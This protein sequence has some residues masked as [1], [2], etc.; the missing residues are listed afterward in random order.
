M[1]HLLI[2]GAALAA[3]GAAGLDY[4]NLNADGMFPFVPS[5]EA[6]AKDSVMDMSHL[7]DAPAGR[8]GFV[9]VVDGRFATDAGRLRLHASNL[10]GPANFPTHAKAERLAERMARFGV[11]CV[12]L[13]YFDAD[14][15]TFMLPHQ[16]GIVAK[17]F[18]TGCRLDPQQ[19]DR[20]DYLV[21]QFKKR[22][23][24]VNVNLHVAR[25]LDA[26]DGFAPGTPWANKG[27]SQFDPR[28]IAAEKAYAKE[29]LEHVNPYTGLAYRD[30]PCVA[31]V[32]LNNE[33]AIFSEYFHGGLDRLP[34][35]YATSL[36]ILWN[37][38][39]L[40]KYG[41]TDKVLEAWAARAADT[42]L[43]PETIA[44]TA[45]DAPVAMDM[46]TWIPEPGKAALD[47]AVAD[48][49]LRLKTARKNDEL[50]PKVHRRVVLKSGRPYT[51]SFRARLLEDVKG[52]KATI[53]FA[54]AN[55]ANG[56][57]ASRGV[58]EKFELKRGWQTFTRTF[59]ANADDAAAEIQF[60][61]LPAGT[62][63]IDDLSFR[64]GGTFAKLDQGRIEEGTMPVVKAGDNVMPATRRDFI[65]F[66]A[67]QERAYFTDMRD[68][69]VKE[70]G[71]KVPV[72]GTQLGYSPA[73]VQASIDYVDNHAYWY[74]PSVHKGWLITNKA[75]VNSPG[76]GC[77]Y[78]LATQRV[79]GK[80][81]TVSEY[82][83]PYPNFFGAEGQPML[84]AFGAYQGWDGVFEYSW[85]NR[86]DSEP[87]HT[88]YFF[89]IAA[90]TDVLA[91][92]PACAAM[93]LRGDVR[94]SAS[95]LSVPLPYD[96]YLD[97]LATRRWCA[98]GIDD[99]PQ[100][101]VPGS[102]FFV[103]RVGVDVREGAELKGAVK[104]VPD[105]QVRTSD[106]GEI[107]W[108]NELKGAGYM[109]VKTRN[110]K[111]FTG[112]V[113][114][115]TFDLGDGVSLAVGRTK[116]DW[117]TVSL[118]SHD[119]NGFGS[120]A[121]ILVAA[122]ALSH[123]GGAKFTETGK[124]SDAISCR[125]ADWGTGK[126]VNEGVPAVVTL[127]S[128]AAATRCWA[129]DERGARTRPVPVVDADGRARVALGPEYA[130]V[131]YEISIR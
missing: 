90:R 50:F 125:D 55:R 111:L 15:G 4:A 88:E 79:L 6:A 85:D 34:Q 121:R 66:L 3:L 72:S 42:A 129:L 13:H 93:Y 63:E 126:T 81:Y 75:M 100:Y 32:E 8:H 105:A 115:R 52:G 60:T 61:R 78:G 98:A 21:A 94:E 92:F 27:V 43:G 9:R 99:D 29:L 127:P 37:D 116:L 24:Y 80:P 87:D 96:R 17:D 128:S 53:G 25:T 70:V 45:F 108:N 36:R 23:I 57:W 123:N 40:K 69:L 56:G 104:P 124:G 107:V 84:R 91:H 54:V 86:F 76:A 117:A 31:V 5:Y 109:A 58:L 82:N 119:G 16:Q 73:H 112:F 11:N 97:R 67:D 103:Q 1:K 122:T 113:R 120:G 83:H 130:T 2:L 26:R 7:L 46:K 18:R 89:S 77:I 14:Y 12:R 62:V 48:G 68:F 33:D 28:V 102:Q 51:V 41:T 95:T 131:W 35:P 22:G 30:D 71:V 106:T 20:Q 10:T 59:V 64:T 118:T 65:A 19:R 74:H 114:G 38:W 44:E 101:K 47:V 39:L 110:V 49:A